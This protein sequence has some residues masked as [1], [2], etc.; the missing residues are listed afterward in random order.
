MA[1]LDGSD[2]TDLRMPG[3]MSPRLVVFNY[4]TDGAGALTVVP[5]SD[6]LG[7]IKITKSSNNYIITT[8]PYK[9]VLFGVMFG[10]ALNSARVDTPDASTVQFNF[11]GAQNS[12]A[13]G[14]CVLLFDA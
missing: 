3:G 2:F 6:P 13:T 12:V 1:A 14:Y 10:T 7:Q 9:A 5:S 8:G 11:A 4:T